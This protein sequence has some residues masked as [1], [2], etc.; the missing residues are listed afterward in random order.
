MDPVCSGRYCVTEMHKKIY[1]S[2]LIDY[3]QAWNELERH[4]VGLLNDRSQRFENGKRNC[5]ME[6]LS[7][8]GKHDKT[9]DIEQN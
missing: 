7:Q 4:L 9:S 8:I 6:Y 3:L 1:H 2:Q 5:Q